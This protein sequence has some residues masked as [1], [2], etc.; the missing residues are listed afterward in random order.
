MNGE[1]YL[2]DF[3]ICTAALGW[4]QY[5]TDQDAWYYGIWVHP[6]KR[7]I[8]SYT[9]GDITIVDCPTEESYHAELAAMAE[10]H[11]DPPPAVI[12]FQCKDGKIIQTNYYDERPT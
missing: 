9:E 10:F 4:K 2:F 3:E 7:Q 6:E 1:R 8:V 5:D 11:G 12:G